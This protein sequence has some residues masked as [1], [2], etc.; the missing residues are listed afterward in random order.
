MFNGYKIKT[1]L[2]YIIEYFDKEQFIE[3]LNNKLK[4][5][6]GILQKFEDPN[7]E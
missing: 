2:K 5:E 1:N 3:C 7:G 6:E 4:F